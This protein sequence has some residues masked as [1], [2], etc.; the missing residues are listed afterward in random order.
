MAHSRS[1]EKRVRQN[2]RSRNRNKSIRT[3]LKTQLKKFQAAEAPA[4]VVE[5]RRA[6]SAVDKAAKG[7]II[8]PN[9]AAREKSR[10]SRAMSAL[11]KKPE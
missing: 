10:L 1:A 7:G 9:K 5:Y 3:G 6:V 8:H 2:E 11:S 4:Q